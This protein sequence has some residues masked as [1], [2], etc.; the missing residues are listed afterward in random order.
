MRSCCVASLLPSATSF[1]R[2]SCPLD[3]EHRSSTA[4]LHP[5]PTAYTLSLLPT[6]ILARQHAGVGAVQMRVLVRPY[7]EEDTCADAIAR[8][9]GHT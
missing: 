3:A 8:G 4:Y 1:P 2:S 5:L 7:A 9:A 6:Y